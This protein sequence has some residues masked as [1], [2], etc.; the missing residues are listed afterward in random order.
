MVNATKITNAV[1]ARTRDSRDLVREIEM[2][3]KDETKIVSS[4]C[5]R[6]GNVIA[7]CK[8]RVLNFIQ[9]MLQTQ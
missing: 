7:E 6:D 3:I 1:E 5:R 2:R 9:L 8:H 4:G